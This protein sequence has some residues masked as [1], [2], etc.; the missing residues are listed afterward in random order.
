MISETVLGHLANRFGSQQENLA[1]EALCFILRTS[2]AAS[3]AFTEFVRQI[4]FDCP[5]DLLFEPQ[6][7][8]LEECVPDIT[9][10]D[11]KGELRLIVENKFW[12]DLTRHQPRTYVRQLRQTK[13][14]A[15][16]LFVVPEAR[17]PLI[18]LEIVR[19]CE[20]DHIPVGDVQRRAAMTTGR[21][22]EGHHIATTSWRSL[23]DALSQAAP[24]DGEIDRR[25]DIA[26][27]RGL[28]N[29]MDEEE[30]LPLKE[31]EITDQHMALRIMNF[32]DL[33]RAIAGEA[34]SMHLCSRGDPR[35]SHLRYSSGAYVEFGNYRAW[36]GFDVVAWYRKGVSPIWVTFLNEAQMP[37]I[38][39]QLRELRKT[40]PQ[41]CYDSQ[42]GRLVMVPILLTPGAEKYK[43]LESAMS[44]IG[45]LAEMLGVRLPSVTRNSED[46]EADHD[47]HTAPQTIVEVGTEG[48]TLTLFG[49][50]DAAGKWRFWTNTD[51]TTF[52]YLLDEEDLCGLG[53]LVNISKP[54]TSF[55]DALSLL[56][57]YRW[58]GFVPLK[59]HPDFS[60]AILREVQKKGT[61]EEIASWINRIH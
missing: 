12:A 34:V 5:E 27:L 7:G 33:S 15:A 16:L 55:C 61:P 52:N 20:A 31:N 24:L 17:V 8:G 37:E 56:D 40:S 23:L 21:L 29:M 45:E 30:I 49:D 38:R 59:I 10:H 11:V 26:Q 47:E 22:G 58:Y 6:R 32:H 51:E 39:A 13:V 35:T 25:N 42:N 44:Q 28:C 14:P 48:G 50:R 1:T 4:G 57:K 3:H 60:A 2:P 54:V 43:I 9:C 41:R 19:Q 36:M 18:W 46:P 53:D